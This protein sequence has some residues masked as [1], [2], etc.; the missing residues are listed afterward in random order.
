MDAIRRHE[1]GSDRLQKPDQ[2]YIRTVFE[3]EFRFD[4]QQLA[5][6]TN[7]GKMRICLD[8]QDGIKLTSEKEIDIESIGDISINCDHKMEISANQ[9]INLEC[10]ES[11]INITNK[12]L[13]DF[14][15]TEVK[16][17]P[18]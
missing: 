7:E 3:Q 18:Q 15:G 16:K 1:E 14:K 12:G 13:L 2:K 10:K 11:K 8:A 9:G 17:E 5:I 4:N 6:S